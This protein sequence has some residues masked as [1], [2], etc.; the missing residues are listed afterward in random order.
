MKKLLLTLMGLVFSVGLFAQNGKTETLTS[1]N[2][3]SPYFL[4]D[5]VFTL[6]TIVEDTTVIYLH[7]QN[8]TS[9]TIQ[10]LQA[11]FFYDSAS[12]ETP[13][14]KWGPVTSTITSK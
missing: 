7:Y 8:P 6:G 5:T 13:I 3:N 14:V 9:Q 4:I 12:F 1:P 10:G 11:R 2:T